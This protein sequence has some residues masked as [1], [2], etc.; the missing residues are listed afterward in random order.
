MAQGYHRMQCR[1]VAYQPPVA[2][3]RNGT[4]TMVRIVGVNP[5]ELT[6]ESGHL[7]RDIGR[8]PCSAVLRLGDP[9]VY[10]LVTGTDAQAPSGLKLGKRSMRSAADLGSSTL[11][12]RLAASSRAAFGYIGPETISVCRP[13]YCTFSVDSVAAQ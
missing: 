9:F 2:A 10:A 5:A 4:M 13:S 6:R 8:L 7:P 11:R 1:H 3:K 12:I